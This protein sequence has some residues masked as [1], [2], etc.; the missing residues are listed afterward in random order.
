M[1]PPD[2]RHLFDAA[3]TP[4]LV[5]DPELTI[6]AVND[7]YLSATTTDRDT[8]VGQSIF[9]AFPDNP[10]D[11]GADG[12]R[13]LRRSLATVLATGAPD[14]MALQRYDIPAGESFE[15]RWWS[16]INT[17]ILAADGTITHLIHRVQDVTDFVRSGRGPGAG[18]LVRLSELE[19]DLFA[20]AREVQDMN[21]RLRAANDELAATGEALREQ[22]RAKDRFIATLSHEL[23]NPLAAIQAAVELLA[24]DVPAGHPAL[25]V[26]ER[27]TGTLI[28][29]TDDL[30]DATRA[31]TGR[32]ELTAERV[33]LRAIVAETAA[34]VAA[35]FASGR[36]A[37]RLDLPPAPVL[38]SG[39][40]IRLA[41]LLS[42]L[43]INALKYTEPGATVAVSVAT[44][45]GDALLVVR[46]DG[47][48][49]DPAIADSLFE[50]FTRAVPAGRTSV[51]GLGLGLAIVRTISEL[52][53][54]TVTAHSAG[55]GTGA[56]FRVRLPPAPSSEVDSPHESAT[57]T[58]PAL[59]FLVIEDNPDLA[60]T[61]RTLLE[62]RGDTATVAT[63]GK[64][65][66]AAVAAAP[67]D[68]VL[69]DLGLPDI[70]GLQIARHLRGHPGTDHLKLIAVSG[71]IQDSDREQ[72]VAAG[73][74]AYLPKPMTLAALDKVLSRWAA[75]V[76]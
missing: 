42:N 17:P 55:P 49:F 12:V 22:Q 2:Y 38:V 76:S 27:Q 59:R 37:L 60:A 54:G 46:D 39:D 28:R 68:V 69:C 56:E 34:D 47:I 71:F 4:Y 23:R 45:A 10:D 31:L 21:L 61:Y 29:M 66:L 30:L 50:V 62:R 48:G 32:L 67:F 41:Q 26:L 75:D 6:V 1:S 63:T 33:D 24:L 3:P 9:A 16:P 43:V 15:E 72:A 51:S 64:A 19:A 53:G 52:H 44:D 57:P 40:R 74:D 25:A 14:A 70:G 13:N 35:E 5:L 7:A 65:G 73:F 11:R 8:L 18:A 36:R 58:R 20:R